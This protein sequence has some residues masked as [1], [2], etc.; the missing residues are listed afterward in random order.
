MDLTF[1][2]LKVRP[3]TW[4]PADADRPASPFDST[5]DQTLD[6]LDRE[7]N[8]LGATAAFLQVE[9]TNSS[10]VR[11]DGLLRAHAKVTH[12]GVVLTV[13]TRRLGTHSY[14]CDRFGQ[15]SWMP[16]PKP[17][18]QEN[19]RAIALGLEALRKVERYGIADRGQQYA[20]FAE[21][22]SG[23]P[24]GSGAMTVD[25]AA[26]LLGTESG[27]GSERLLDDPKRVASA[28]RVAA[29][30]HHPDA[31]GDPEMFRRLTEARD[32]LRGDQ[33]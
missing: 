13:E 6:L 7:L 10:D 24:M 30:L 25:E 31:G 32:L 27:V 2:P 11:V 23:T 3:D 22:G 8:H 19:L 4:K 9:L 29:Q 28:Y 5:Y 20:G 1:R 12:P 18:W 33:R 15:R 26:E 17:A 16:D 14:P 21:L